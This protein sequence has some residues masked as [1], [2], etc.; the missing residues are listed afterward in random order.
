MVEARQPKRSSVKKSALPGASAN[1]VTTG[2]T[3]SSPMFVE[4]FIRRPVLAW[5][6][7][8]VLLLLG[9]VSYFY[10]NVRQ[11]PQVDIPRITVLT[12]YEGANPEVMEAQVTRLLEEGFA[13]L[14][15]LKQ[16]T[17]DSQSGQSKIVLQFQENRSLDGAAADVRDR[18]SRLE[19]LPKEATTPRVT[20]ADADAAAV[21]QLTL[22][23]DRHDVAAMYDYVQR[24]LKSEVETTGG[25][26]SVEVYGG[27]PYEMQV[28]LDPAKLAAYNL[29][30]LEVSDALKQ[31]NFSKPAGRLG[32][33]DQEFLLTTKAQLSRAEE[34]NNLALFEKD[35][36]IVKVSDVGH[37]KLSQKETRFRVRYNGKEAVVLDV[38]AQSKANPVQIS[39]DIYKKL[40]TIRANLPKGM[41]VDVAFDQSEFVKASIDRVFSSIWEAVFLVFLVVLLFLRSFRVVLIPLVTIPLSLVGSFFLI[42]L[43]GFTINVLTLLAL[44]LAVGLVVDDAIVVLENI[45]RHVEEGMKPFAAAVKGIREIQFSVIGM[46]LT[47]VAVYAPIAFA[48]GFIGKLFI[49]FALTLAGAV[50]LSGFVALVLSPMMCANLLKA[51]GKESAYP[52]WTPGFALQGFQLLSRFLDFFELCIARITAWYTKM[53]PAVLAHPW[54]LFSVALVA[55][56]VGGALALYVVPKESTPSEDQGRMR[57]IA[58]PPAGATLAYL[59]EH[60]GKID[61]IVAD[62][63]EVQRRLLIEQV[64]DHS[65]VQAFLVPRPKRKTCRS[66]VEGVQEKMSQNI[67]GVRPYAMCASGGLGGESPRPFALVVQTQRSYEE[68]V[69]VVRNVRRMMD[70]HPGVKN[71]DWNLPQEQKEYQVEI[72]RPLAASSGVGLYSIAT[73]LDLLIGGRKVSTFEKDSKVYPVKVMLEAED[74]QNPN[75]LKNLLV[76]GRKDNKEFM[77]PLQEL[78]QIKERLVNPAI[79]HH[80]RMRAIRVEAA[81]V[82]GADMAKMYEQLGQ[83]IR[84]T[85]PAGFRISPTGTLKRFLEEQN[86]TLMIFSLAL[87]FVFLI[88]A[89]QFESFRDPFIILFTVPLAL[90]GGVLTLWIVPGGSVNIYSQI[91]L[92]TL[93]GLIT[94]HGILL[95]DFANQRLQE[96]MTPLEAVVGACRLRLR[97][98]LMTTFAM[99]LGAVPLV[100]GLEP[101]FETRR[102]VGWVIIGGMTFGTFFTLFVIP[103]VYALFSKPYNLAIAKTSA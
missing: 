52:R 27:A 89:A 79:S 97:P 76:K 102:Q 82:P 46:T 32:N 44:V 38:N 58:Q 28:V 36:Y 29:T 100:L 85:L 87:V 98:I 14:E 24:A 34:F 83:D 39:A 77:V 74:K 17:S 22:T 1:S 63:P 10:L 62:V 2:K 69:D 81:L 8:I 16:M 45:Y 57:V 56:I 80:D 96:G 86:T 19:G 47:L 37:V 68:L 49:E 53:L 30:A 7:N 103:A 43:L 90:A 11:Y 40:P 65:Y 101:G 9:L 67:S 51:P 73:G 84:Q 75:D 31:Q 60:V 72:D 92:I 20:K 66:L 23:S 13:S 99:V 48:T 41:S 21:M 18:L 15:G 5:V 55:G 50:L 25:V 3:I 26:A 33:Q 6:L 91:G 94:K 61:T 59:D 64:D 78:L 71:S 95:V 35:N 12:Q 54:R 88:M 4:R 70:S 42:Y 93:M